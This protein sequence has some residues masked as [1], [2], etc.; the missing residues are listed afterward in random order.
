[1]NRSLKTRTMVL[2]GVFTAIMI[3][4]T[5]VPFLGY[6][7]VGVIRA[8]LVHIPVIIG[9][10]V[11]GPKHGTFLGFVFGC[12]SLWMSTFSPTP[13]SFA[14]SP[15]YQAGDIGGSPLS[16]IVCFVPRILIGIVAYYVFK[17]VK[18]LFHNKKTGETAGLIAAGL[19]GSLTN[20]L[21][22]MNLIYFLFQDNYAAV[23]GI[24]TKALYG[25]ILGVIAANGI[26]EAIVAA[27]FTVVIAKILLRFQI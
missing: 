18:R 12:I 6:I 20:T 4:M 16:L 8:T 13:L 11:I 25:V 27:I 3:V 21:L 23:K 14:F 22:V 2:T 19:A 5:S 10:I 17:L 26:P 9:A 24:S 15:F 7:P 1:M